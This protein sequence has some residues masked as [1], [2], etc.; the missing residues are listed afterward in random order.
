MKRTEKQQIVEELSQTFKENKGLWLIDFRG[1][2]V[3]G[4]TELRRK[5]A[6]IQSH[7][8]VVKNS[9]ALRAARDTSIEQ[10]KA[11]FD[12][13]TAIAYTAEDPVALVKVVTEFA[14]EH[15]EISFKAGILDGML[16]SSDQVKELAQMPSR[17]GLISKLLFLLTAPLRQL[18]MA[19]RSPLGD[20][21]SV[22]RQVQERKEKESGG[23]GQESE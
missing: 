6:E 1:I 22:V 17:E 19:L 11:F 20:L 10:L 2:D 18:A 9:L 3:A 15:P 4:I 23:S 12:G 5:I 21:T 16:I 7:Y 13:P 14:R 8:R